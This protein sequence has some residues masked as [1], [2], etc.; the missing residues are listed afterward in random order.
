VDDEV[1]AHVERVLREPVVALDRLSEDG[2]RN[3]VARVRLAAGG[4]AIVKRRIGQG[5]ERA[6]AFF[7]DWAGPAFLSTLGADAEPAPSGPPHAPRFLGGDAAA[8]VIVLEDVAHAGTMVDALTGSDPAAA[9]AALLALAERLGRMH[10][11]TAPRLDD[12]ARARAALDPGADGLGWLGRYARGAL[13]DDALAELAR[14]GLDAGS[15]VRDE[16]GGLSSALAGAGPFRAYIH[17][18]PCPDNVLRTEAG[19]RLIDFE[20]GGIGQALLDGVYAEMAFP[21]CW[22]ASRV[23]DPLVQRMETTYRREL[24]RGC[25]A[26]A[27]DRL[28]DAAYAAAC[29]AWLLVILRVAGRPDERWGIA[30]VQ[31]RLVH[32][33]ERVARVCTERRCLPALAGLAADVAAWVRGRLPELEPLPLYPAFR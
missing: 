4:T 3:Y 13:L 14:I 29:A 5:A 27:D 11:D 26:A 22:C 10:A 9:E 19:L 7:D 12:Y 8:G 25:P 33:A 2:R 6:A 17:G 18:D 28:F 32:R 23:P 16:L 30:G 20:G 31:Q 24:T 1:R 15:A 21:S